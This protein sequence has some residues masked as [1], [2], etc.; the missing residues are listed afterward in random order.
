MKEQNET[1]WIKTPK[2]TN[3]PFDIT[4]L[5]LPGDLKVPINK[6]N[7]GMVTVAVHLHIQ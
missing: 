1:A 5:P 4:S 7:L 3:R 2:I 6:T